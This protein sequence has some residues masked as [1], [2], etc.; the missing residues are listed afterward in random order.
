MP[1]AGHGRGATLWSSSTAAATSAPPE[2]VRLQQLRDGLVGARAGP[3][4]TAIFGRLLRGDA[5]TCA[6]DAIAYVSAL[7]PDLVPSGLG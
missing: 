3:R 4:D 2:L 6:D 5:D 7:R 1:G